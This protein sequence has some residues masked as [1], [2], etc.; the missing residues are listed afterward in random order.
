MLVIAEGIK[1]GYSDKKLLEGVNLNIENNDKIGLVGRN[2]YGKSTFLKILAKVIEPDMGD[3]TYIG[4]T[5]VSYLSQD[6]TINTKNSVIDEV[7]KNTKGDSESIHIAKSIL[8]KLE[9]TDYDQVIEN[10]SGGEKRK[11]ALACCLV[12]ECDLLILD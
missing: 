10:L 6:L 7:V 9:L 1:K 12:K 8:T 3:V 4:K 5:K 11:V 2:G